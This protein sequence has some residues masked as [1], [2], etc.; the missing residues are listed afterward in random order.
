MNTRKK[1][2]SLFGLKD[3]L[4]TG[5]LNS[6]A[7]LPTKKTMHE[8]NP[9]NYTNTEEKSQWKYKVTRSKFI[10]W[11]HTWWKRHLCF[12]Q[13]QVWNC[14]SRPLW[15]KITILLLLLPDVH[16]T[17]DMEPIQQT[18]WQSCAVFCVSWRTYMKRQLS[19]W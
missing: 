4:S 9:Q 3:F 13:F 7:N 11:L 8:D 12:P 2:S 19:S 16:C 14:L 17:Q 10:I 18:V 15:F 6:H 1:F 5:Q